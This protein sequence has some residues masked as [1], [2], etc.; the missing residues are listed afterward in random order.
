MAQSA[1]DPLA[2]RLEEQDQ[3]IRIL[4]RKLELA[5]ENAAATASSTS[6]VRAGVSGFSVSSADGRNVLR[7]RGTLNADGRYFAAF[8][9]TANLG[10]GVPGSSAYESANGFLLRKVRPYIEGTVG[11]LYDFRLQPEFGGGRT[12]ILDAFVAARLRPW[13]VITAGKFK[14][15]VGLERLQT[16]QYNKFIELGFPSSLAPNRDIG[17]QFSGTALG[18]ALSY[19]AGLFN[20]VIDGSGAEN[21]P[22]ADAD[23]D[24]QREW[25][26]RIFALPFAHADSYYLR[27][28][29]VGLS[30][31]KGSKRGAA[32][33]SLAAGSGTATPPVTQVVAVVTTSTW[34]PTYRTP[35]QQ[36]LFGYRGDNAVTL[37]LNEAAYADGRHTRLSPQ[38]YYYYGPLGVLAEYIESKQAVSRH[39]GATTTRSATLT[40]TA[41]QVAASWFLTGEDAA[42]NSV[43]PRNNFAIGQPGTG[44][45]EIA[46]R[47]QQLDVDDDAFIAGAASFANPATAV[48]AAAGYSVALN[49]YPNQSVR[50]SLEYDHTR[51]TGGAGTTGVIADRK[52]ETA[53]VTRF[54]IAF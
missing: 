9:A 33:V 1:D 49:W 42:Y 13:A 38:A 31:S 54:A 51:F 22:S 19:A 26:A 27:G 48:T 34:L 6:L 2:R 24:N 23:A 10:N 18:G 20:G 3:R 11:G 39:A 47:Y 41:W 8:D 52:D 40:H 53:W 46:A 25:A 29:G 43:T 4:E 30:A 15:P 16:E 36:A 14:N 21:N 50:W 7:L 44:A 17:L 12:V 37:T 5:D 28:L 45:W 32:E 35:T